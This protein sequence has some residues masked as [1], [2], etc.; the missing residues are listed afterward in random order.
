MAQLVQGK[1]PAI[2]QGMH[3]HE[4][5]V[6]IRVWEQELR[7][8]GAIHLDLVFPARTEL[9]RGALDI[10]EDLSPS[11]DVCLSGLDCLCG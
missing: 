4:S 6:H 9:L 2:W 11:K 10:S 5:Q 3:A 8:A 1:P 7:P